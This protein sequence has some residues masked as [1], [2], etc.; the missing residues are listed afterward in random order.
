MKRATA[1]HLAL[2][3][4]FS[5][6]LCLTAS[7]AKAQLRKTYE[8]QREYIEQI[9]STQLTTDSTAT[10][11]ENGGVLRITLHDTLGTDRPALAEGG[12]VTLHYACQLITGSSLSATSNL[13]DTN[14]AGTAQTAKWN[15]GDSSRFSPVT[16]RV[17]KLLVEGLRLGLPGVRAGDECYILFTGEKGYGAKT[18]GNIPAGSALAYH[19]WIGAV[20]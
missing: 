17:D 14:H 13:M 5:A 1:R 6:T 11:S 9:A 7:C 2:C 18:R 10:L 16:L 8:K 15:T 12:T 4:T 19:L 20:E 3:A